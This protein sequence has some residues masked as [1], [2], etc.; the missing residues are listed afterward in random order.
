MTSSTWR[1][2]HYRQISTKRIRR[3]L[4]QNRNKNKGLRLLRHPTWT[5]F[6]DYA[7]YF[8]FKTPLGRLLFIFQSLGLV[9]IFFISQTYWPKYMQWLHNSTTSLVDEF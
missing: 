9:H 7:K 4:K 3:T 6:I 1:M 5:N 2:H 8:Y